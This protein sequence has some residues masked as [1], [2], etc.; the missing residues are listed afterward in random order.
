MGSSQ[1]IGR[2]EGD[3]AEPVGMAGARAGRSREGRDIERD[4]ALPLQRDAAVVGK[5]HR[6]LEAFGPQRVHEPRRGLGQSADPG[7]WRKLGR[8]EKDVHPTSLAEKVGAF[9]LPRGPPCGQPP[10]L[11]SVAMER[12]H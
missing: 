7:Q 10:V 11:P 3:F 5:G 8:G 6:D 9:V 4:P 2:D 1:A 12:F